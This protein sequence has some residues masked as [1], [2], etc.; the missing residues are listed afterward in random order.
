M[1]KQT[2]RMD[3]HINVWT[4]IRLNSSRLQINTNQ[5]LEAAYLFI[6]HCLIL[7]VQIVI[8]H[9][10]VFKVF[11]WDHYQSIKTWRFGTCE[12]SGIYAYI[13][14]YIFVVHQCQLLNH[15]PHSLLMVNKWPYLATSKHLSNNWIWT[16]ISINWAHWFII[17]F[18]CDCNM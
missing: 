7:N 18:I 5:L 15:R 1:N 3:Q 13:Y 4:V 11:H 17:N 6:T 2:K 14:M 16:S 9:G 10:Y 8:N 12:L